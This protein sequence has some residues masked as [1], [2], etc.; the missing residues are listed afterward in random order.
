MLT[1]SLS[2][3]ELDEAG[4]PAGVVFAMLV[5]STV[6]S[7]CAMSAMDVYANTWPWKNAQS[8]LLNGHVARFGSHVTFARL[9]LC[10]LQV[11]YVYD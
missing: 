5:R 7:I 11:I 1:A 4:E 2:E 9:K 10:Y 8:N 3:A 6:G